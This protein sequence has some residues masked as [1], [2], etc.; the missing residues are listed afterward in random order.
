MSD[1]E[2][3][4]VDDEKLMRSTYAV[5][6]AVCG[7]WTKAKGPRPVKQ[8]RCFLHLGWKRGKR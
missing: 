3:V 1:A 5:R 6:C 4:L 8:P 2:R 7:R